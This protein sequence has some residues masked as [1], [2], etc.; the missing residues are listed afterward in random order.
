MDWLL[1]RFVP[2]V[3][4]IASNAAAG[5]CAIGDGCCKRRWRRI[6]DWNCSKNKFW[7]I[8]LTRLNVF[9]HFLADDLDIELFE[10]NSA[11]QCPTIDR[12]QIVGNQNWVQRWFGRQN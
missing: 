1:E 6:S 10:H 7:K 8:I 4:F 11:C 9:G 5:T 3:G 2:L 12:K